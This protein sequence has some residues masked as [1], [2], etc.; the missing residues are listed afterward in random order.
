MLCKV[1]PTELNENTELD[2]REEDETLLKHLLTWP[3]WQGFLKFIGK[4]TIKLDGLELNNVNKCWLRN[5]FFNTK[6]MCPRG[7][8]QNSILEDGCIH[9]SFLQS[10][11]EVNECSRAENDLIG[12]LPVFYFVMRFGQKPLV[13]Y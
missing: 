2:E 5:R 11:R 4:K 6:L 3:T 10:R 9:R 8:V 7:F 1:W 12:I 13:K